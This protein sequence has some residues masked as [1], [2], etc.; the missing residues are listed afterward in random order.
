MP[1]D[2]FRIEA[3]LRAVESRKQITHTEAL[4]LRDYLRLLE[5]RVLALTLGTPEAT[6]LTLHYDQDDG[7]LK[8]GDLDWLTSQEDA[9]ALRV[10][11]SKYVTVVFTKTES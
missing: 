4:D 8:I 11:L 3:V 6:V 1:I 10:E 7:M 9:E 5:R 2:H